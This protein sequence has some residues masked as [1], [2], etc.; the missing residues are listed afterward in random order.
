MFNYLEALPYKNQPTRTEIEVVALNVF[1]II[2]AELF[3]SIPYNNQINP[4]IV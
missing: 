1:E 4:P 3:N 2:T